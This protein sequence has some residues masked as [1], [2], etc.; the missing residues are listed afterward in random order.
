MKRFAFYEVTDWASSE[1][2]ESYRHI[3]DTTYRRITDDSDIEGDFGTRAGWASEMATR[4]AKQNNARILVALFRP[5]V[6]KDIEPVYFVSPWRSKEAREALAKA[7]HW[8]EEYEEYE[9]PDSAAL[10]EQ[11]D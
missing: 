7:V 6:P 2:G 4:L 3:V 10:A 9:G 5:E 8:S 11:G 1:T